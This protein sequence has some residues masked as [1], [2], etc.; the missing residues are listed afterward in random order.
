MEMEGDGSEVVE[1]VK[2]KAARSLTSPT[3]EEIEEE[4]MIGTFRAFKLVR[5]LHDGPRLDRAAPTGQA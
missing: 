2:P 3:A 5:P 4:E 1:G